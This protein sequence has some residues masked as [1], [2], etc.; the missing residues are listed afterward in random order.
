MRIE[1]R[2]RDELDRRQRPAG[3]AFVAYNCPVSGDGHYTVVD[4]ESKLR[5]LERICKIII[6]CASCE[7]E[8]EIVLRK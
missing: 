1:I 5:I 4:S 2:G 8:H 6:T 7:G 3:Y